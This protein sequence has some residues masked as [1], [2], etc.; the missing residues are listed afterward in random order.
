MKNIFISP[1]TKILEAMKILG[2]TSSK[3]LIVSGK[4]KFF[5]GTLN[6]GDLRRGILKGLSGKETIKS[7]YQKKPIVIFEKEF[8]LNLAKNLM[9]KN[10][11]SILPVL[12][13]KNLVTNYLVWNEIFGEKKQS[14]FLKNINFIIMAGGKGTR[15]APFTK[16]LPKPLLPIDDKPIIQ[17]I[18]ER[19]LN[20]GGKNFFI[21]V[22]YKSL[23]LKSFFNE[24]KPQYKVK[25]L[26]E[27]QPLGT[28]GGLQLHRKNLNKN[29][30]FLCNCDVLLDADFSEMYSF[31]NKRKNDLTIIA[32]TKNYEIPYGICQIDKKGK[33]K[34]IVEKPKSKL[35]VNTGFYIMKRQILN[36]IPK[37]R[38]FHMTQLIELAKKKKF[39]V[40]V[41][42]IRDND[43]IDIGQLSNYTNIQ[44]QLDKK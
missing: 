10:Q 24:L 23:L 21:S 30:I 14:D 39:T 35:F 1:T 36:L 40:A 11:L 43:W 13:K 38:F 42:P 4:N 37:N 32:S 5:Y 17:H 2:S 9:R 8:S 26:E 22:N 15:L 34:K 41:Y 29:D 28:V 20:F 19:F 16:V 25:F 33:L 12:N 44:E 6:D 31:H 18:I 27:H 7:I 3:C